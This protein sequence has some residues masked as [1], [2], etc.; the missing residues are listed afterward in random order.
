M[1]SKILVALDHGD[2]CAILFEQ[3][4]TLAQATGSALMLLS[5]LEPDGDGSLGMPFDYGYPLPLGVDNSIWLEV[6]QEAEA[7]GLERL[8]SFTDQ[9]TATGVATEFTQTIGSPGRAIC[10][11]AKT[12]AADL[13]VV[14]SHG[15]KG[16]SELFLGSVSNYVMHHAPCSVL[17]VDAQTLTKVTVKTANVAATKRQ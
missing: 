5:V 4:V 2:T 3:A 13:I 9:A 7:Q 11:L 1:F 10:A 8:R 15:R 12:W 16:I 17:V 6:Y 14:G